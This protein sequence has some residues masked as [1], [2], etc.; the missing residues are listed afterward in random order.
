M[1]EECYAIA[2]ET[3]DRGQE[4]D[5]GELATYSPPGE[6]AVYIARVIEPDDD[7]QAQVFKADSAEFPE[8]RPVSTVVQ[9]VQFGDEEDDEDE[10]DGGGD[11]GAGDDGDEDDEGDEETS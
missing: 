5:Y 2:D 7:T 8:F 9:D 1:D 4:V 6:D 10:G 3:G 11:D